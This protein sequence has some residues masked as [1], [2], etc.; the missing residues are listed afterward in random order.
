MYINEFQYYKTLFFYIKKIPIVGNSKKNLLSLY[1]NIPDMIKL[2][3]TRNSI[4]LI[5][6]FLNETKERICNGIEITFTAKAQLE[7]QEL[8]LEHNITLADI[9]H[10]ILNLNVENYYRG[11]DASNQ[12]DFQVCAFST[13][14]GSNEIEI[15]LKYGLE[16]N[17]LQIL[18]FSNHI[19]N[20]PMSKQFS[21]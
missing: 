1:K 19:P 12:N 15:Y 21:K 6:G 10:T 17:G 7:L 9:E 14:T 4:K 11:I 13:T 18:I 3:Y 8:M 2:P 20:F 5:K 16:N